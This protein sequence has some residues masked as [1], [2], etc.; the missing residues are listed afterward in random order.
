MEA[1][2]IKYNTI[3]NKPVKFSGKT[4]VNKQMT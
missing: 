3:C 2:G 1:T 4:L